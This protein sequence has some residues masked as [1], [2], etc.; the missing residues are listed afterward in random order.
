MKPQGIG[1]RS[2]A[3]VARDPRRS[4]SEHE[5]CLGL[6]AKCTKASA[7]ASRRRKMSLDIPSYRTSDCRPYGRNWKGSAVLLLQPR[8]PVQHH[9]ERLG[10]VARALRAGEEKP[11]GVGCHPVVCALR[12]IVPGVEET[13]WNP[14]LKRLVRGH[15]HRHYRAGRCSI[16]D[17]L[18]VE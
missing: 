15:I 7:A 8:L 11:G 12:H 18:A 4:T 2:L 1:I 3:A 14:E 16:E 6:G 9:R 13:P 10:S 17:V 5:R